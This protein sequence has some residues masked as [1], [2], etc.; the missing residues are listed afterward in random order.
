MTSVIVI[1]DDKDIVNITSELLELH[2]MNV[3]GKGYDGLEAVE[4]FDKLH[5]DLVLLDVM[6]PQYDGLYALRKIR[7]KDPIANV[8]IVSGGFSES[9][10]KKLRSLKPTKILFKPIDVSILVDLF[11][12]ESNSLMLVKIKYKFKEDKKFYTCILTYEQ[13]KNFRELPIIKEC[14]AI[15]EAKKISEGY[16]N[17]MQEALDQAAKN[18]TSHIRELSEIVL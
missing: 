13:Y 15:K 7:E 3:I 6:M 10:E 12:V 8:I 4:L 17:E 9:V 18:D 16:Q 5:P 2:G 14:K 1:D 11:L